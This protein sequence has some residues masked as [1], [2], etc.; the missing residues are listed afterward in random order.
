MTDYERA[1]QLATNAHAG[2]KRN[3]GEDYIEHCKRVASNFD[4]IERA[5]TV[6]VL[7]DILED[8][9]VSFNE[10][11]DLFGPATAEKVAR[12][13]HNKED[14]YLDYILCVREDELATRVKLADIAD[15]LNG[16]T[17]TLRS[18]YELARHI[19]ES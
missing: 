4:A 12:L 5:K 9:P 17:G 2:Q 7:H 6:A 19:L 10:L 14:S 15:N 1:L 13:T 11:L 8:T 16:A 18:K 3:N